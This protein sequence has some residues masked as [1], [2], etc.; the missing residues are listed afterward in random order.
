[1]N[2]S[3]RT[4]NNVTLSPGSDGM[5]ESC[6]MG[7]CTESRSQLRPLGLHICV[8]RSA[9]CRVHKKKAIFQSS[10]VHMLSIYLNIIRI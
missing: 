5:D 2:L 8:F 1:M 9:L 4:S 3:E 7:S 10:N 6:N